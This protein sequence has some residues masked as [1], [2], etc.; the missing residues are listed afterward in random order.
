MTSQRERA[1]THEYE[2]GHSDRELKRLATQAELVDPFTRE[3]FRE[4]GLALGMR[5][6]AGC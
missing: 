3:F 1:R 4:G 6:L 5:V 2:L